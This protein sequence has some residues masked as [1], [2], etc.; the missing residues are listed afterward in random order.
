M[1]SQAL[2]DVKP[3]DFVLLP[4]L[5]VFIAFMFLNG[6]Q[7]MLFVFKGGPLSYVA[8]THLVQLAGVV[9]VVL[10]SQEAYDTGSIVVCLSMHTVYAGSATP[11]PL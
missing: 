6:V 4:S 8:L 11:P 10:R 2:S 1:D 5:V 7:N 3:S 9:T